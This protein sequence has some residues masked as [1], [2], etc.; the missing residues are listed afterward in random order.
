M[1]DLRYHQCYCIHRPDYYCLR[2]A[3]VHK[4]QFNENLI[5]LEVKNVDLDENVCCLTSFLHDDMTNKQIR[6]VI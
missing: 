5:Q 4:L 1:L 2:L 3:E 6:F